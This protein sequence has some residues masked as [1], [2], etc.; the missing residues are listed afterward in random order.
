MEFKTLFPI[1]KKHLADDYKNYIN[2]EAM[3]NEIETWDEPIDF[4]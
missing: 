2:L 3:F 1:M 4:V